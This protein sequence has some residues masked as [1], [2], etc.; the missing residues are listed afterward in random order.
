MYRNSK[1][2]SFPSRHEGCPL[3]LSEAMS[4][5]CFSIVSNIPPNK[6]LTKNFKYAY[7][8]EVDNSNELANKLLYA[9]THE[10]EIEK[11][12]I[13]GRKAIIERCDLE[14]CCK[15][16]QDGV[17]SYS[18]WN[19]KKFFKHIE[20]ISKKSNSIFLKS[21]ITQSLKSLL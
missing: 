12:A 3:A 18:T 11:I 4:Q 6:L 14:K 19:I 21:D 8:H 9:C 2:F 16:I 20:K 10:E 5:G 1:I 7:N 17:F 15:R 13:K